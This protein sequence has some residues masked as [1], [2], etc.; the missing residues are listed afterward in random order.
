ML[1]SID[2]TSDLNLKEDNIVRKL[3]KHLTKAEIDE[4]SDDPLFYMVNDQGKPISPELVDVKYWYL[5]AGIGS[6]YDAL[7]EGRQKKI[8]FEIQRKRY[9]KQ[10]IE[11]C[12]CH[13]P[14]QQSQHYHKKN[15]EN[16]QTVKDQIFE[17]KFTYT[18]IK[19]YQSRNNFE[20]RFRT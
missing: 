3:C 20:E 6:D 19:N 14:S 17:R 7:Q 15:I 12:K 13:I 9:L 1:P 4:I 8:N 2:T 5:E 16:A 11:L 18:S 10:G